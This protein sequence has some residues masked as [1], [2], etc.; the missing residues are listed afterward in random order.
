[1]HIK[2]KTV[3]AKTNTLKPSS[4][5]TKLVVNKSRIKGNATEYMVAKCLVSMGYK[6]LNDGYS[7]KRMTAMGKDYKANKANKLL[8]RKVCQGLVC[9]LKAETKAEAVTF[10]LM[11]DTSGSSSSITRTTTDIVVHSDPP[12]NIS[13]KHNNLSLKHQKANKLWSQMRMCASR[14]TRFIAA[15]EKIEDE[16]HAK[17]SKGGYVAFAELPPTAKTDLYERVNA[18]TMTHLLTG[19]KKDVR[20]YLDF[21]LDLPT[22]NK[23]ILNCDGTKNT[24]KILQVCIPDQQTVTKVQRNGNFLEVHL[25]ANVLVR[26]RLHSC[27]TNVTKKLGLKYDTQVKGGLVEVVAL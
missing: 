6:P 2:N 12:I 21:I 19:P 10:S 9:I 22:Q 3:N 8:E 4:I 1:M 11:R 26:M 18:L 23:Y 7:K 20:G 25:G 15:Y 16:W 27:T 17:W 24:V 5:K 14:K 13:I